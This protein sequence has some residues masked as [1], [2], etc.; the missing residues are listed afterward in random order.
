[1]KCDVRSK[2]LRGQRAQS[3]EHRVIVPGDDIIPFS[4]KR[5]VPLHHKQFE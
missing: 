5:T 4:P 2:F 1:V 3:I